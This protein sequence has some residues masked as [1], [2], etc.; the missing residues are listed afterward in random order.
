MTSLA[1]FPTTDNPP[2]YL[3]GLDRLARHPWSFSSA[4]HSGD[5][6]GSG[7]RQEAI[8]P[9]KKYSTMLLFQ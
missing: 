8:V 6:Y 9:A 1:D 7:G 4:L 5:S 2:I 3:H